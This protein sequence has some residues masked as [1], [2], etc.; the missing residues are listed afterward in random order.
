MQKNVF[1]LL[2]LLMHLLGKA[3][4]SPAHYFDS[5]PQFEVTG[6]VR[7]A[8]INNDGMPDAITLV[9][10]FPA[11]SIRIFFALGNGQYARQT[12]MAF[13]NTGSIEY[14]ETA[15]V[16]ADGWADIVVATN[17]GTKLSWYENNTG[18]FT[19]RPLASGLDF[20]TM[21]LVKD[22][23]RN[24]L[25]DILALQ[26]VEVVLYRQSSPGVFMPGSVVHSGTEFYAIDAG[27][28]NSDSLP[29]ISVAS[30]GF[31]VLLNAGNGQFNLHSQAGLGLCFGLQSA[32]LDND[33]DMDIAMYETLRGIHFYRNDGN[34]HFSFADTI[35]NSSDNFEM[36]GMADFDCDGDKDVYTTMRQLSRV[37]WMENKLGE[38][39]SLPN[40]VHT[41][42]GQLVAAVYAAD[43][44]ADGKDD[45]IWGNK[46]NGINDNV[47][48]CP[49]CHFAF[50][51]NISGAVYQWEAD[52]GSGYAPLSG[53]AVYSGVGTNTLHLTAPPTNWYGNKY[54]CRVNNAIVSNEFVLKFSTSWTG[55]YSTSW[56]NPLNWGCGIL[57][58]ANTDVTIEGN[59]PRH[60]QLNSNGFCRSLLLL[61]GATM[62]CGTGAGLIITGK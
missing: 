13:Q 11:D 26:H 43:M 34:G 6:Q 25:P 21:L 23:D 28:Y 31:E 40:T 20:T 12:A 29:D 47:N 18:V 22:F 38:G 41:Q 16:N 61:P 30:G 49:L 54:R 5:L 15:D 35:I 57:P 51:S 19:E 36:F 42:S 59:V 60:P 44:N 32:D 27:F 2:L 55:A 17:N 39:F 8:D 48:E 46:R 45:I 24:G 9:N 56:E 3:Q 7:A 10:H 4:F 50:A 1:L 58:D 14:F 53:G 33:R 37:V 52:T 62:L